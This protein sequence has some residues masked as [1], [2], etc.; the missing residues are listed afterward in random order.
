MSFSEQS[1]VVGIH[2]KDSTRGV[3]AASPGG[4]IVPMCRMTG[5]VVPEG[6]G[7][8]VGR[9]VS[10]SS[11]DH[12]QSLTSDG[13]YARALHAEEHAATDRIAAVLADDANLAL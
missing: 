8:G 6:K 3:T 5:R 10:G 4:V 1:R 11:R 9:G 12:L 2:P 7:R 13:V